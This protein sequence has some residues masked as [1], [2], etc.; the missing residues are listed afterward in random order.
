MCYISGKI[1]Q[2]LPLLDDN[3]NYTSFSENVNDLIFLD[4]IDD[5]IEFNDDLDNE[6]AK[7]LWLGVLRDNM[8]NP[9][10]LL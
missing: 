6:L 7:D 2:T 8:D 10:S 1:R 9:D 3:A 4:G 5:E